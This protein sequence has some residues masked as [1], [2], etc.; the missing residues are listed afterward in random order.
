M[1]SVCTVYTGPHYA[2]AEQAATNPQIGTPRTSGERRGFV[3]NESVIC[4]HMRTQRLRLVFECVWHS[5]YYSHSLQPPKLFFCKF[6]SLCLPFGKNPS[7]RSLQSLL[8]NSRASET[9]R[10]QGTPLEKRTQVWFGIPVQ[11]PID[12]DYMMPRLPENQK[13]KIP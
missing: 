6:S 2:K 7:R 10:V 11:I 13:I 8:V 5:Q 4:F 3:E 12:Y 9:V 1:T